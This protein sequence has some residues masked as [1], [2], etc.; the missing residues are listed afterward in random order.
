[1]TISAFSELLQ[2]LGFA[3]KTQGDRLIISKVPALLRQAPIAKIM[4]DLL[5]FL[6][7]LNT[8]M[9]DR[10]VNDFCAFLVQTLK[11]HQSNDINWTE[12]SG[13]A[14]FDLLLELCSE[15]LLNYQAILFREPD[16]SLLVQGF[17]HD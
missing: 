5:A 14:L 13:S 3:F 8:D 4:P 12:Q 10:Q 17:S 2:R 15:T 9:D 6:S 1:K 16:L 11:Q 7:L